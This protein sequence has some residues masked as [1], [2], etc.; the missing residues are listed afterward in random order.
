MGADRL[1]D[2]SGNAGFTLQ[3]RSVVGDERQMGASSKSGGWAASDLR[4]WMQDEMYPALPDDVR[5]A[6]KTVAKGYNPEG[7]SKVSE[8]AD[9]LFIISYKELFGSGKYGDDGAWYRYWAEHTA[10]EDRIMRTLAGEARI[11]WLRNQ[12]ID[13]NYSNVTHLGGENRNPQTSWRYAV[14]CFCV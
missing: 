2:G 5:A 4:A 9:R 3:C 11:W 10:A 13:G 12:I 14:P 6:V 1:A 7:G 8:S